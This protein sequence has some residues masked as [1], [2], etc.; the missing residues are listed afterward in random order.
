M[1]MFQCFCFTSPFLL[2]FASSFVLMAAIAIDRLISVVLPITYNH[3]NK[4]IYFILVTLCILTNG[5]FN[6]SLAWEEVQD[7][8]GNTTFKVKCNGITSTLHHNSI[9]FMS[10]SLF[11]EIFSAAIYVIIWYLLRHGMRN[12]CNKFIFVIN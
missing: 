8:A 3:L 9:Y 7:V 5:L 2:L 1:T 10:I 6:V 4:K 12:N 11:F